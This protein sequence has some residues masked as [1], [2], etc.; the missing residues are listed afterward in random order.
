MKA[1]KLFS[2]ILLA[3]ALAF[4]ACEPFDYEAPSPSD[5][6]PWTATHTIAQLLEKFASEK[7]DFFPVRSNS[8]AANLFSVDSIPATGNDVIITGRVVSSDRDGFGVMPIGQVISIRCNGLAIG[9]YADVYQLGCVYYNHDSDT[10]KQG[11]EP[12]RI[13]YTSFISR[14]QIV[15]SPDPAAVVADTMTIEQIKNS[16][17]EVHS[18]LVVIEDAEFTG[19]GKDPF[20]PVELDETNSFWGRPKPNITGVPLAREITDPTGEKIYVSTSE[21]AAFAND[22]LPLGHVGDMTV[23]VSYYRDKERNEGDF[24]LNVRSTDDFK[25][26]Q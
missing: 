21:F 20:D 17:R 19:W 22:T 15:G 18:R 4:V 16:G 13:P 1:N 14:C 2:T 9:K 8:G 3:G 7:G 24:Q 23:V 5:A 25:I 12:G 6:A 11:Y 10:R 26:K